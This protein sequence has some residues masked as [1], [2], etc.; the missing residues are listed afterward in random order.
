M[1][2]KSK[3]KGSTHERAYSNF[4]TK[5]FKQPFARVPNSGAYTGGANSFR[6]ARLDENQAK[7][8]KGDIIP[9]DNWIKWCCECKNYAEFPF[10]QLWSGDVKILDTW[11][12]QCIAA[13]DERDFSFIAFKISRKGQFVA[14]KNSHEVLKYDNYFRYSNPQSGEWIIMDS[15][16]FWQLNAETVKTI[17]Q[18]VK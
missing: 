11:I 8:F 10:H 3:T 12:A 1:A 16:R 14:V 9:P 18:A 17:C 5:L 4:L 6:K 15:D 2:S 13:S 7:T